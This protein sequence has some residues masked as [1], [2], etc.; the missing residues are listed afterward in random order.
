[1]SQKISRREFLKLSSITIGAAAFTTLSPTD[2]R[3]A[4]PQTSL[5]RV[6]IVKA[7][8]LNRPNRLG[9][10]IGYVDRDDVLQV[11]RN[12]VGE[13]FYPHNHVW[14][15]IPQGFVYSSW[16]QPVK[17]EIQTPLTVLPDGGFFAEVSVP[18]T[19]ARTAPEPTAPLVYFSVDPT[20]DSKDYPEYKSR[21][22]YSAVF[23]IDQ[24]AGDSQGGVWYRIQ[25]DQAPNFFW[26]SG[27]HLRPITPTEIAP[28]SPN[29]SDKTIITNVKTN[30]LMAYEGKTEVFRT[31]IASGA[32]FFA[33]DG[34]EHAGIKAGGTYNIYSKRISRHMA[35]GVFPNGYDLPG[36][37]WVSYWHA[38]AAIHSTYWHNDFGRP[39]SHGC[40][41]CSPEAAKWLFRWTTPAVDYNPGKI[42]VEWDNRGTIVDIQGEPAPVQDDSG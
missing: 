12:V 25:N 34:S 10:T 8:V 14:T 38:G 41:N 40:L 18:Y 31:R 7:R 9:E 28:I 19:Q 4:Q 33:P 16:V 13:G 37:A 26:A 36:I 29:V 23:K 24:I 30:W 11:Y 39:R 27:L 1:M 5:G 2:L 32:S 3:L 17:E 42:E 22:Y 6:A 15:E 21:V 20:A 35:G